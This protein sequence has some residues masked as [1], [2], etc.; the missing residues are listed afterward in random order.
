MPD[1]SVIRSAGRS[2]SKRTRGTD[3]SL[4]MD[5]TVEDNPEAPS[6]KKALANE[7]WKRIAFKWIV[8]GGIPAMAICSVLMIGELTKPEEQIDLS[9]ASVAANGSEGKPVAQKSL[10]TW[11]ATDPSPL[12][13][14]VIVS[15]DGYTS[16]LAPEPEEGTQEQKATYRY[17]DHEFTV[18]RGDALFRAT[19]EVAVDDVLGAVAT[20]TPSL[21]PIVEVEQIKG[22]STW[23]G[24]QNTTAEQPVVQAIGTWAQA[25]T[26]G[27]PL[28][29]RQVTGD[30][31]TERSYVPL[32]GVE[33]LIGVEVVTAGFV[34]DPE[35]KDVL[36]DEIVV[37]VGLRLW[38]DGGRPVL[39]ENEQEQA[40]PQISYDLLVRD[41]N[42][43]AP[44]VVAWG[45][46]G[47]GPDLKAYSN[48]VH[49]S[50]L[51]FEDAPAEQ[52]ADPAAT[53]DGS[54]G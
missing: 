9:A 14:A 22:L 21:T 15:W 49:V 23:F 41:A 45:A 26:S 4:W 30:K 2:A 43:A 50:E 51:V 17:E 16:E 18:K 54:E 8:W 10:E 53:G 27:D 19:V 28:L 25:Y 11:I 34:P 36:P 29:L 46:P 3:R 31:S 24:M 47:S 52:P 12:P 38:W 48:A 20:A 13:G 40:P 35:K 1:R 39:G 32:T 42:S 44:V 37:R 7:R 6:V 33:E 5:P